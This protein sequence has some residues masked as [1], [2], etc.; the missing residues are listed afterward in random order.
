MDTGDDRLSLI[1]DFPIAFRVD[2]WALY[3]S[4]KEAETSFA[5]PY[6]MKLLS[7]GALSDK[8]A[9]YVYFYLDEEGEQPGID[10]AFI[11]VNDLI[12][13]QDL[14]LYIGQFA[15]SDPMLKSE[16]RLTHDSY[17]AYTTFVGNSQIR[18]KYDRGL[19][20]TYGLPTG[21]GVTL[22]AVNGNGIG[23]GFDNDNNKVFAGHL[24]Q[25]IGEHIGLGAYGLFGMEESDPLATGAM[26]E[27]EVMLFGVNGGISLGPLDLAF[28]YL[29]REDTNPLFMAPNNEYEFA[30]D[31]LIAEL[32]FWP[33]GDASTWYAVLLYNWMNSDDDANSVAAT[34]PDFA[35]AAMMGNYD[36]QTVTAH[37]GY[38]VKTNV[39]LGIEVTQDIENEETMAGIGIVTAF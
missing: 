29:H 36:Y 17:H 13:G 30:S 21:T 3:D 37:W 32:T 16:L 10:D 5:T 34:S 38:L 11:M 33:R 27:N 1:R 2:T 19:M 31:G 20:L 9:Y 14:D 35:S 7:G 26:Q 4:G 12:E 24:S 22:Q 8:L 25:D 6:L 28:Q 15:L 18:L 39:R 23:E